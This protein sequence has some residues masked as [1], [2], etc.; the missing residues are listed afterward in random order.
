MCQALKEIYADGVTEGREEGIFS[1][2]KHMTD[3]GFSPE[4]IERY[5]GI[6]GK[7]IRQAMEC[8]QREIR[9]LQETLEKQQ[10]WLEYFLEYRDRTEVDRLMLVNLVKR[11]EVYEQKR[12][13]I[14]F[15]FE[16]EFEKVLGLLETVNRTKPDQRVEA[17]LKGKGAE[18]SA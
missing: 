8:Q 3:H 15:W 11:I 9:N 5:T 14:H 18:A 6:S 2:V 10:E 17:F 4:D 16:D 12:I 13:I 7:E 1:V